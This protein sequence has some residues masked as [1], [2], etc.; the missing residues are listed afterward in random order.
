[1]EQSPLLAACETPFAMPNGWIPEGVPS[2]SVQLSWTPDSGTSVRPIPEPAT[3]L[4][5]VMGLAAIS[6][7][8]GLAALRVGRSPLDAAKPERFVD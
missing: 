6:R 5:A 1:M 8:R 7:R 2:K 3:V 4:L